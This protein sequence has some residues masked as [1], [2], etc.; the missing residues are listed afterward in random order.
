MGIEQGGTRKLD[1]V[2]TVGGDV[3][4]TN[5]KP[6]GSNKMPSLDTVGHAGYVIPV[7][8]IPTDASKNN[9]SI[10]ITVTNGTITQI[11]KTIG[12]NTYTKTITWTNG[13]ITAV[14]AWS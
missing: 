3:S 4:V 7:E 13:F 2:T 1:S 5:L 14:S 11:V 10:A 9:P 12:G 6:D 8:K